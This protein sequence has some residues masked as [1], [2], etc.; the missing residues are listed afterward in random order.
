MALG[1]CGNAFGEPEL[2]PHFGAIGRATAAVGEALG[3]AGFTGV[4]G[5]DFVLSAAGPLIIETNPR[6]VASLP[7]AT[8]AGMAMGRAPLL[9]KALLL[10]LGVAPDRLVEP[11]LEHV[12]GVP[13]MPPTSQVIVHRLEGDPQPRPAMRSGVYGIAARQPPRFLRPGAWLRD[14]AGNEEA[15]LLIREPDEPVSPAKEFARVYMFGAEA[16]RTA[17]LR[18]LVAAVRGLP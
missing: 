14:L 3:R 4:F 17:G 15:L 18:E 6:M 7:L 9:L 13:P 11:G 8:Q 2:E 5:V 12:D 16:E 10:G 1:S